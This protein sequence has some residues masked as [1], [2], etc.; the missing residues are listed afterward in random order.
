M[1]IEKKTTSCNFLFPVV[2]KASDPYALH[3]PLPDRI[4]GKIFHIKKSLNRL[5]QEPSSENRFS[6][7]KQFL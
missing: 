5:V 2:M 1:S 4:K 6:L 7:Q 3:K